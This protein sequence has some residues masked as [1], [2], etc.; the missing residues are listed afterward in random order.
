[1][2]E[3][4]LQLSVRGVRY[5]IKTWGAGEPLWMLHGF[6]GSSITWTEIAPLLSKNRTVVA[7]DLLGHGQTES[8]SNAKRYT[9]E[10]QIEDLEEIRKQLQFSPIELLGY[11]MGGRVA[12]SYALLKK[13]SIRKLILESSSPGIQTPAERSNR[14]QLDYSLSDKIVNEGIESFVDYWQDIPL[15][16][17]Q[18]QLSQAVQKKIREERLSQNPTGLANSLV[19]MGTGSQPS[20]WDKLQELN[21]P[22]LLLTGSKDE[23][24]VKIA[25]LMEMLLPQATHTNVLDAGHAIHVELPQIFGKIV[26]EFILST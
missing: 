24:F 11:S 15:F 7:I 25:S 8:P 26:E 2:N 1:M 10:Q 17:S 6:T 14:S 5:H 4:A 12:L 22:V 19:G 20:W 3:K 13:D 23:K 9:M 16:E 18:K 21:L